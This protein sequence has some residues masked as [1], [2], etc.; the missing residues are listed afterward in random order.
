MHYNNANNHGR[1][2]E[3]INHNGRQHMTKYCSDSLSAQWS[4]QAIIMVS[5]L[6]LDDHKINGVAT[7]LFYTGVIDHLIDMVLN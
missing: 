6:D 5:R 2:I 1:Q 3:H 7:D 4:H